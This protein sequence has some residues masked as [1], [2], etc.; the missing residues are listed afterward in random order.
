MVK[1]VATLGTSPGG[2]YETYK[3]LTTG[4]YEGENV[5]PVTID[6]VYVVKTADPEVQLAGKLV[7]KI[8]LCLNEKV[9]IAEIPLPMSDVTSKEDYEVIRRELRNK[10]QPGDYV[11]FTGG[12]KAMSVAAAIVA[13]DLRATPVTTIIPQEEYGRIQSELKEIRK[14]KEL[15]KK[16]LAGACDDTLKNYISKLVSH[17]SRTFLL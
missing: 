14:D 2:I 11:D 3:N 16:V 9:S 10:V 8:F 6:E 1:L 13:K 4:N 15:E 17:K 5:Y 7:M 12:R